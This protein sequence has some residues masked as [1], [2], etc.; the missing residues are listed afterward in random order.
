VYKNLVQY[1][2]MTRGGHFAAF[3][4][5]KLVAD[6]IKAFAKKVLDFEKENSDK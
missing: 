3:E 5:P 1:T 6:D 2:E 4:E